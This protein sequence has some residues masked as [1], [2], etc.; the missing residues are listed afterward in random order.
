MSA[1]I[2]YR[3]LAGS[4]GSHS[5]RGS[6]GGQGSMECTNQGDGSAAPAKLPY[7]AGASTNLPDKEFAVPTS[8]VWQSPY[9]LV[10]VSEKI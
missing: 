3:L 8:V 4:R 10:N 9:Q 5:S 7:A 2:Y 1:S 6:H